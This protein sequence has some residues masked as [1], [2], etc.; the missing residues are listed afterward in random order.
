[1]AIRGANDGLWD[2]DLKEKKVF[3]SPRW[4]EML[5]YDENDVFDSP[6]DW[7]DKIHPTYRRQ[8][9]AEIDAHLA[10]QTPRF[11]SEYQMLHVNG[12]YVWMLAR[13]IALR[14]DAGQ[15][16]RISGSQTDITLRKHN[17][18]KLAHAA[19]HDALTGLPKSGSIFKSLRTSD[20]KSGTSQ[21]LSRGCSLS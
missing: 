14:D 21:I 11:E 12:E 17:E 16:I 1:L 15:A 2:W 13:G 10:G 20:C 9:R 19:F 3:Y 8:V 5:G 18:N 7:L 4:K 6:E